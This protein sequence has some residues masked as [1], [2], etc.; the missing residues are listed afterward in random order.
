MVN[1]DDGEEIKLGRWLD[2]QRGHMKKMKVR[3][4]RLA[5]LQLLIDQG[6]L[7]G[8]TIE[9]DEKKWNWCYEALLQFSVDHGNCLVPNS[10]MVKLP[11][12]QM[13]KLGVWMSTQRHL[14]KKGGSKL[15]KD[16][17]FKL[18]KLVD[19]GRRHQFLWLHFQFS[20]LLIL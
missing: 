6:H 19:E 18:Q 8:D 10:Y 11:N 5:K 17:E 13:Q 16:R 1:S 15:R 3:E 4:D 12:G 20:V 2:R 14:Q 7:I 9:E